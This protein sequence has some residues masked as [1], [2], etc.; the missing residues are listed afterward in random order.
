[1]SLRISIGT[2]LRITPS[3]TYV[4]PA[5]PIIQDGNTVA[6]YLADDLTTITKDGSNFVSRW[7]DKLGSGHDLIQAI[8]TRQPLWVTPDYIQF[9]GID[10]VMKCVAF[11][12]YRPEFIYMIVKHITW[13]LNDKFFDGDASNLGWIQQSVAGPGIT[14]F[15][16][17]ASGLNNNLAINTWGVLRCLFN[18]LAGNSSKLRI[19]ETA[20][21]LWNC[22]ALHMGGFT[23]A[24]RGGGTVG[25]ANISVKEIICRKIA[26]TLEDETDIYNYLVGRIPA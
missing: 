26:D 1:M 3:G 9:D 21:T 7:N 25:Y 13:T 23:L 14:A 17:T 16:G 6:W 4:D 5:I 18:T 12:W 19:N 8:G 22:G 2:N 20:P 11:T 24:A 10:D 15:A